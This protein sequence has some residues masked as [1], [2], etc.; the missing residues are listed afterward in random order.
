MFHTQGSLILIVDLALKIQSADSGCLALGDEL[1]S[2]LPALFLPF[3]VRTEPVGR[4]VSFSTSYFARVSV[5][6]RH[7]R[8][9]YEQKS[10]EKSPY[11][12]K[13]QGS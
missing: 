9:F 8:Y 6:A 12:M 4:V 2:Y 7:R 3:S 5:P 13:K 1:S 10:G 11:L